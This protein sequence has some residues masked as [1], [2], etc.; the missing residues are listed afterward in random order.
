MMNFHWRN[1]TDSDKSL[2]ESWF[3]EETRRLTGCGDGWAEFYSYWM[4]REDTRSGENFWSLLAC[5]ED[6][7]AAVFVIAESDGMFTFSECAVD[8]QKRGRGIGKESLAE[9]VVSA[10]TILGKPIREALAVIFPDNVQSQKIFQ[11]AGFRHAGT[12][13]DGDAMYY[14][15]A[16]SMECY[17]G[18]DCSRCVTR[19]ASRLGLASLRESAVRFYR[20]TVGRTICEGEVHCEGGRTEAVFSLCGECP[21]ARCC[22]NTG[23]DSCR[24]CQNPCAEYQTYKANFVNRCHQI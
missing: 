2:V 24:Q 21:F 15:Y 14:V 8:P 6:V 9:L 16:E 4:D 18:H 22:K 23:L 3:D 13:P 17:C 5:E 1:Y 12:H 20:D 7:P 11:S 19:W 10:R